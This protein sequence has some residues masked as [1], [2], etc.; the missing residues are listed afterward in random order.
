MRWLIPVLAVCWQPAVCAQESRDGAE[1]DERNWYRVEVIV[2][3]YSSALAQEAE[4]WP[5]FPPLAYPPRLQRLRDEPVEETGDRPYQLTT[6]EDSAPHPDIEIDWDSSIDELYAEYRRSQQTDTDTDT[7]DGQGGGEAAGTGP[8][9][10]DLPDQYTVLRPFVRLDASRHEL[11]SRRLQRSKGRRVLFHAS[12]YQPLRSRDDTAPLLIEGS[13]RQG[14]YPA[15]QGTIRLYVSRYVHLE[16]DLWL[17]TEGDYLPEGWKMPNPPLAP[18][19]QAQDSSFFQVRLPPDWLYRPYLSN[20]IENIYG[21]RSL[22][23]YR[24]R[25]AVALQQKRRMRSGEL[26]YIDHPLLGLLIKV[27][28]YE[29]E[30]FFEVEEQV[31]RR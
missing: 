28:P 26:H 25:H 2:F 7:S 13:L 31:S 8:Q 22:P 17:N 16:T 24:W 15:L 23:E 1:H 12:W 10:A 30:P 3:N 21:E 14:D 18:E 11:N 19:P 6:I 20:P 27:T 9:M 29:F 4:K 5:L